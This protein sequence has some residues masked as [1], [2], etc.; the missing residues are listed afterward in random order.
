MPSDSSYT[1]MAWDDDIKKYVCKACIKELI[2]NVT[3]GATNE[4]SETL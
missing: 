2:K 3:E 1:E 4:L